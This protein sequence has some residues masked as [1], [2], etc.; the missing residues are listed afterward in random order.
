MSNVLIAKYLTAYPK[1]AQIKPT[2]AKSVR[3]KQMLTN[4][5]TNKSTE[6]V[7]DGENTKQ[8]GVRFTHT[9]LTLREFTQVLE[10][11]GHRFHHRGCGNAV[12]EVAV[13]D[14]QAWQEL[15]DFVKEKTSEP[16]TWSMIFVLDEE[17]VLYS[18]SVYAYS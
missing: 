11:M 18:Q 3:G 14:L 17:D 2:L 13:P 5:Q 6:A 7:N 12:M 15:S 4:I 1:L 8:V 16:L 10:E 9:T